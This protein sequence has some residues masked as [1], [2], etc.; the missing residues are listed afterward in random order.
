MP[1]GSAS[2]WLGGLHLDTFPGPSL[3]VRIAH[4]AHSFGADIL[5]SSADLVQNP[6][7]D[8]GSAIFTTREMINQAH[9]LG[10]T[11]KPW[12]VRHIPKT[13]PART[14]CLLCGPRLGKPVRRRRRFSEL[15]SRWHHHRLCVPGGIYGHFLK[16]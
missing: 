6:A 2:P 13:I 8:A 9:A 5:S 15:A 16:F 3:G 4:A 11:V 14:L 7:F 10:M 1:N 12:T